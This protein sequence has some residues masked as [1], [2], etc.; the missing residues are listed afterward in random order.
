MDIYEQFEIVT[1]EKA[2]TMI[3]E[4]VSAISTCDEVEV[5]GLLIQVSPHP[6]VMVLKGKGK[7]IPHA[8]AK[9]SLKRIK[10]LPN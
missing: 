9:N 6:V 3:G 8:V 1:L 5:Q 4:L 10:T 7:A 2:N